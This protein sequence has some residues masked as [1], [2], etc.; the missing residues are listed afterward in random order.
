MANLDYIGV[1]LIVITQVSGH[2]SL[3]YEY[4]YIYGNL[5]IYMHTYAHSSAT[6][7]DKSALNMKPKWQ[8]VG[9]V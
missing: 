6:V 5:H 7:Q 8:A 4:I 3:N 9:T 2:R 1:H